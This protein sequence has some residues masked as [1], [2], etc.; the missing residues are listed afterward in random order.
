[1]V[2]GVHKMFYNNTEISVHWNFPV[3]SRGRSR[4]YQA[5]CTAWRRE[6]LRLRLSLPDWW[7]VDP[8]HFG[9]RRRP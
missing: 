5:R 9:P 2:G 8:T 6:F 7:D 4:T 1:M 3:S